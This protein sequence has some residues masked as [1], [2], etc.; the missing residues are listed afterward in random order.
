MKISMR[1]IEEKLLKYNPRT[2][3]STERLEITG[4]RLLSTADKMRPDILYIAPLQDF[5]S[6]PQF[7]DTILCVNGPDW[8]MLDSRDENE[9]LAS[10]LDI[11]DELGTW[12]EELNK[13]AG[14]GRNMQ[15]FIDISKNALPFPMFISDVPGDV[16]GFSKSF[17]IGEVDEYWDSI[18]LSGHT[19]ED[20]FVGKIFDA[21]HNVRDDWDVSPRIYQTVHG[22]IIGVHMQNDREIIG[23]ITIVE[24]GRTFSDGIH[25]L[26]CIFKDA[27]EKALL[28]SGKN[29][30]L[31]TTVALVRE[32]LD[33]EEADAEYMW[34]RIYGH[35][36]KPAGD[37][38]MLLIRNTQRTD[39]N[40]RG[41][42]SRKLTGS[43]IP[44]FSMAYHD[45]ALAIVACSDE[46]A[47]IQKLHEQL[48]GFEY[49][50]GASL[51]FSS[52]QYLKGAF[53]Q[54]ELAMRAGAGASGAVNQCV[55]YAYLYILNQLAEKKEISDGL[56]HP[57]LFVLK[58]YDE[59][60]RS[61]LYETLFEFL[62]LERNVVATAKRMFIHR[63]SMLYRLQRLEKLLGL[64]LDDLNVRMYL[65]LSF[66]IDMAQN[67][68]AY[69][70]N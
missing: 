45:Y 48:A 34:S 20:M 39:I 21:Q 66:Q 60:H 32:H 68:A 49:V 46:N 70:D 40:F 56:L 15:Y 2:N 10:V 57:A 36:G 59:K 17:G 65:L 22:R 69:I 24:H 61:S 16:I 5:S 7:C 3:I 67:G 33:G 19:H 43:G 47:F 42:L 44:C 35:L 6:D 38:K 13:A 63:N 28:K 27:A 1:I 11:F 26:I 12:E 29:A 54:A 37:F 50:C 14:E 51:P 64:D 52:A 23:A 4:A 62:R 53:T 25:Q 9:V 30:E 55:D 58:K 41:N 8:I 18:V 31:R